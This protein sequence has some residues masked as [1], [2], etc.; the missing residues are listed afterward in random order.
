MRKVIIFI[1]LMAILLVPMVAA[2]V[3]KAPRIA[4]REIVER[5]TR[6]E[7][8]QKALNERIDDVNK[9][10]D[11]L[12]AE[13]SGRFQAMD[14]RFDTLQWMLG[15]FITISLVIFGFVLRMQWQMQRR[16]TGL[17]ATLN[18]HKDE[19]AFLKNLIER[20][21]PPKGVL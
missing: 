19:L 5:L 6:L 16:Q 8:G 1:S 9:R 14:K 21:L 20:L 10:I 7:E 18:A 11:D 4:D 17:E 12:R 13:M 15:L 2:A 3:E